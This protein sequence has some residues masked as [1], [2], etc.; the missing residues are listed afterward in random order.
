MLATAPANPMLAL[1]QQIVALNGGGDPRYK[2][3]PHAGTAD[4]IPSTPYNYG[5]GGLFGTYGL[6]RELISLRVQPRGLASILPVYPSQ[7]LYPLFG[8]I[9]GFNDVTGGNKNGVCDDPQ[10]AG[11]TVGCMQT[12]TFGRYEF[13]TRTLEVNRLGQQI[14]RGEYQDLVILNDPLYQPQPGVVNPSQNFT[15]SLNRE[16]AWRFGELAVAFQNK[17]TRQLWRGNPANNTAQGGY[18]EFPGL[19][20]LIGTGKKDAETGAV[21][22]NL[23]SLLVDYKYGSLTDT[24]TQYGGGLL[25]VMTYTMRMLQSRAMTTGLD[26]VNWALVMRE[27]LFYELAAIWPCQYMT[28]NCTTMSPNTT[29]QVMASDQINMRDDMRNN[30]YLMLDGIR[31]NVV[32]DNSLLENSSGTVGAANV[33][34]GQLASDIYIIPLSAMGGSLPTTYWQYYDYSGPNAIM[35]TMSDGQGLASEY[36]SDSGRYLWHFKSPINWC[37]QWL[38]KTELRV[39]LR[40]PQL[41]ARIKNIRYAPLMHPNDAY[42][43]QPYFQQPG[44]VAGRNAPSYYNEWH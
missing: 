36:W 7:Q 31:Y 19:D 11:A 43:D 9:S 5:P 26:P 33:P 32:F 21:C 24:G 10:T 44:G 28:T 2:A 3:A 27:E 17:L 15:Q 35:P 41:A 30:Q 34:A 13:Q 42:G 4:A 14:N 23:D 39:L 8:Y 1:A 37:V 12:A 22:P 16:I 20:I 25:R 40:T 6:S 38:A 29:Q 18:K